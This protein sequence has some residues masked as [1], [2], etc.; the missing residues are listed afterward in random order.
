M[1]TMD[2]ATPPA[3]I[4]ASWP[5]PS[6]AFILLQGAFRSDPPKGPAEFIASTLVEDSLA[7]TASARL[8]EYRYRDNNLEVQRERARYARL[9]GDEIIARA[10]RHDLRAEFELGR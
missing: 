1:M 5:G 2:A 8:A 3:I 6:L 7:R 4:R 10:A 9:T